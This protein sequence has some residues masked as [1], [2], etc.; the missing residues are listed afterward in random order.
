[1]LKGSAKR[2]PDRDDCRMT[3]GAFTDLEADADPILAPWLKPPAKIS[4][5]TL[6]PDVLAAHAR[7]ALLPSTRGAHVLTGTPLTDARGKAHVARELGLW[8]GAHDYYAV[9]GGAPRKF[10][11]YGGGVLSTSPLDRFHEWRWVNAVLASLVF[12]ARLTGR[13]LVLPAI[14]DFQRYHDAADHVDL[15]AVEDFLGGPR[16]WREA[17]FFGSPRLDVRESATVASATV[18]G[19]AITIT[20]AA[21]LGAAA[22]DPPRATATALP[23][24]P[25]A[26]QIDA[27]A[28]LLAVDA[29]VLALDLERA[30]MPLAECF[31]G[32]PWDCSGPIGRGAVV[33]EVGL[34]VSRLPWCRTK[35]GFEHV[36]AP[37]GEAAPVGLAPSKTCLVR[38]ETGLVRAAPVADL[39]GVG[40]N[41]HVGLAPAPV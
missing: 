28:A 30:P 13:V 4:Y 23:K 5:E 14:F 41:A 36:K 33:R 34:L 31:H 22:A 19:D 8:P 18:D 10:L 11:V 7:P 6:H 35:L 12:T 15:G 1:M 40:V 26:A 25:K 32:A 38:L 17:N 9:G 39:G 37:N 16:S 3:A 27:W 21:P 29:D 20:A 24:A 2:H